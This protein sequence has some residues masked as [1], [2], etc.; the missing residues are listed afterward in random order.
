MNT[1]PVRSS[2]LF[3]AAALWIGFLWGLAEATLFFIVPDVFLTLVALFSLRHSAKVLGCILLG[4]ITGGSI[5]YFAAV[6]APRRSRDMV[7]EVPFVSAA[8]LDKTQA[9]LGKNGIWTMVKRPRAGVPYKVYAVQA[10]RY[11]SW[12]GFMLVSILARLERFAPFWLAASLL[13]LLFRKSIATRPGA[14][15]AMHALMWSAG[16]A[17]YWSVI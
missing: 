6:A 9:D 17:W 4:A 10:P 3:G 7:V 13:G 8:M 16:Y 11:A 14:A 12:R 2:F 5:M 15:V 1:N